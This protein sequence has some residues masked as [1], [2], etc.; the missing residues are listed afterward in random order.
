MARRGQKGNGYVVFTASASFITEKRSITEVAKFLGCPEKG[1]SLCSAVYNGYA[2]DGI[3]I[4]KK[5]EA[6][7]LSMRDLLRTCREYDRRWV[8][9]NDDYTEAKY[10]RYRYEALEYAENVGWQKNKVF[11][12]SKVEEFLSEDLYL[13][14][15]P[16]LPLQ[17][18]TE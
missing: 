14:I 15:D 4:L 6:K 5:E 10:F 16:Q 18:V 11:K 13:S 12:A 1:K 17:L 3:V 8:S 2:V 9:A 7:S